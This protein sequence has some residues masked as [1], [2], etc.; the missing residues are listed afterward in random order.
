VSAELNAQT[1]PLSLS[2]THTHAV[3]LSLVRQDADV[4]ESKLAVDLKL[5]MKSTA[6]WLVAPS[7][8]MLHHNGRQFEIEVNCEQLDYG[9]C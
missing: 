6:P 5:R 2:L 3:S 9:A 1:L 7:N 4:R 8:L